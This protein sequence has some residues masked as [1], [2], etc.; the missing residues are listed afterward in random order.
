MRRVA[1]GIPAPDS[2]SSRQVRTQNDRRG[3]VHSGIIE[4][5]VTNDWR[6]DLCDPLRA[7]VSSAPIPLATATSVQ[8]RVI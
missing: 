5:G 1:K 8:S 6:L 7:P 3:S 4:A 2:L